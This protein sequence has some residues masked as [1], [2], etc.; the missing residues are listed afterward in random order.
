[1]SITASRVRPRARRVLVVANDDITERGIRDLVAPDGRDDPIETLVVAPALNAFLGRRVSDDA[2]AGREAEVRIVQAVL[3]LSAAGIPSSGIVGDAD[4]LL[5]IEDALSVFDA[6]EVVI[7]VTWQ[8]SEGWLGE[9]LAERARARLNVPVR[10]AIVASG[11][12][13]RPAAA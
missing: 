11:N 5:A 7:A 8:H 6:D 13:W 1:M 4:P 9:K 12:T 10:H 2:T 3:C